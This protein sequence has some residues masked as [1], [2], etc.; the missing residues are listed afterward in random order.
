MEDQKMSFFQ[1]IFKSITNFEFYTY[2]LKESLGR[3]F[4]YLVLLS[5]LLGAIGLIQPIIGVNEGIN[6]AIQY[7]QADV[8]EFTFANG[9]LDVQ[10]EMP[11][12]MGEEESVFIIDT[13]G[14]LDATVLDDYESGVFISR[15]EMISK[16]NGFETRRINFSQLRELSFTKSDVER[17]LP[18]LR[19]IHLIVMIFGLAGAILAK[20]ISTLF[21]SLLG[22]IVNAVK[23]AGLSYKDIYKLGIY[24]IT[25]PAII[26]LIIG[27]MPFEIPFFSVI[28]YGVVV[29]YLWKAMDEIK[30]QKEEKIDDDDLADLT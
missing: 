17:W 6:L 10:G 14:Q 2:I 22:L 8:P 13:S 30:V 21:I 12:I 7:F 26:K 19:W 3:A 20:L 24:A 28:Y 16:E 1:R 15:Y 18:H 9:E 5:L 4:L 27:Q 25:L 29:F 11:I 23:K